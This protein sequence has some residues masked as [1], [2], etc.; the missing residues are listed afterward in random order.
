MFGFPARPRPWEFSTNAL[1]HE[2]AEL[3]I[4]LQ[5]RALAL[6]NPR[7]SDGD[8]AVAEHLLMVARHAGIATIQ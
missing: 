7:C 2:I 3:V 8:I 4:N 5:G 6:G 1:R